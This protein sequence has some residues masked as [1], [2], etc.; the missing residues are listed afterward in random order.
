MPSYRVHMRCFLMDQPLP[1]MSALAV[2]CVLL[3]SV[4]FGESAES[5]N[6]R[7]GARG[8]SLARNEAAVEDSRGPK[9]TLSYS[10]ETSGRN[11]V[12]NFMYFIPLISMTLPAREEHQERLYSCRPGFGPLMGS[13]PANRQK[14][15]ECFAKTLPVVYPA[16]A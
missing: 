8:A 1:R 10:Q 16:F 6:S 9:V 11:P 2:V 13:A 15:P 4:R 14:P 3:L 7:D 12:S 5:L